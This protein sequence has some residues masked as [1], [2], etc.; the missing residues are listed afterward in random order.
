MYNLGVY[1]YSLEGALLASSEISVETLLYEG[2]TDSTACNFNPAATDDDGSCVGT[3]EC[4]SDEVTV[5]LTL[6]TEM[7]GGEVSFIL[8]D[9]N[10][11]L[12]EG[13]G[14]NDYDVAYAS[15]CLSDSAGCLELDMIDSFGDGWNGA[16]LEVS[17]P[18]LGVS[19]GTF[20]LEE[21]YHQTVSFGLE[22]ETQIVETEGCT[23][24]YAFNYD[25]YATVDRS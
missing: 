6:Q 14:L 20:S 21:G 3:L 18:D 16:S 23:D 25:P 24:P 22:C 1:V 13:Q 8:S 7:W 4:G 2:C 17:I 11:V 15:F 10:G 19:L 9:D 12:A 5:L